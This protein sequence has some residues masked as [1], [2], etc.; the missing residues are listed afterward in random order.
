MTVSIDGV[1]IR[2]RSRYGSFAIIIAEIVLSFFVYVSFAAHILWPESSRAAAGVSSLLSYEGRLMD[3]SGNPLGGTGEPYCF[4]F[5]IY[6]AQ[7]AG[8]KLWPAGTPNVTVATTTDG[9]FN[10]LVGQA[11]ALTYNFYDNS[12][13]Y[14]NV[15]VNTATSTNGST[16]SGSWE[17]LSPRQSIAATG[18][19]RTAE[20]VYSTTLFTDVSNSRVQIGSGTGGG[21]PKMLGLDVQNTNQ[22]VGQ[23]C[24]TSGTMWYNS[25]QSMALVCEGGFIQAVGTATTTIAAIQANGGTPISVGT[26]VFSNGNGVS[27]GINGQTI[28]AS[29]NAGGGTTLQ[30]YEPYPAMSASA[31][32][33]SNNNSSGAASFLQFNVRDY[34]EAD[35]MNLAASASFA[36]LGTS[37][38]SQSYTLNYGIYTRGTGASSSLLSQIMSNSFSVGMSWN[39]STVTVSQPTST[40]SA[41]FTY[42]TTSSNNSGLS[43]LYTGLKQ[44]QLPVNSTLAPGNYWIGLMNR[45]SSSSVSGGLKISIAGLALGSSLA[46]N[47]PLGSH[48]SAFSTGTNATRNIGGNWYLGNGSFT[49]AGQTNLPS[50]VALSAI[51]ANIS[52]RPYLRFYAS[53]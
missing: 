35:F 52:I 14:L 24:S 46:N 18:Y 29:V 1:R 20:N 39:N 9:V 8:A 41:G 2:R 44:F 47:A 30:S 37:N 5:S 45:N 48:S 33:S 31:L 16:C 42:G 25:A 40:N 12:S 38:G 32:L 27:W 50:T 10:A 15:E 22:Y 51:T 17:T 6:D 4:R 36:T 11:D 26:V 49:S 23:T 19:A 34:V 21:S 53:T 28:T 13:V 3:T 43:S 7:S